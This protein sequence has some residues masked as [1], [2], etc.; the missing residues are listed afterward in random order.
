[1]LWDFTSNVASTPK[2]TTIVD[3]VETID[4]YIALERC[5]FFLD[6]F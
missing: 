3:F 1:M 5:E 4:C 6:E 2:V